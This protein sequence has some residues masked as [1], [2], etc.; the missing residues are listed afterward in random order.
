VARAPEEE[1]HTLIGYEILFPGT[2]TVISEPRACYVI[3]SIHKEKNYY[4][5]YRFTWIDKETFVPWREEQY[6]RK[7]RLYKIL[8]KRFELKDGYWIQT[9]WN[10][11][12]LQRNFRQIIFILDHRI[13]V[14]ISEAELT[15]DYIR[16]EFAW[17]KIPKIPS[18]FKIPPKPRGIK[19]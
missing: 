8:E 3:R 16:K 1:T 6:D 18:D 9:L 4:L 12:N 7:G 13:N 11:L 15:H 2:C 5:S 19:E 17:R 14:P 10:H